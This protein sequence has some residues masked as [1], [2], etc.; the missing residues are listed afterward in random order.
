MKEV[1]NISYQRFKLQ[2]RFFKFIG[3]NLPSEHTVRALHKSLARDDV[4]Q[5][6]LTEHIYNKQVAFMKHLSEFG[7][8]VLDKHNVNNELT[9]HHTKPE[10]EIWVK[11]GNDHGKGSFKMALHISNINKPN[12][13]N[14]THL[15]A[16]AKV[17]GTT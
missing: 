5:K 9:W 7:T 12:S 17:P 1:M 10:D 3:A 13:K 14:N 2:P 4:E 6:S 15:I 16:M 8:K 11:I